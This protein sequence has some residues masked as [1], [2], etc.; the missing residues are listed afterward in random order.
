[1]IKT[2]VIHL[3]D[4][5]TGST[6]LQSVLRSGGYT[7]PSGQTVFYPGESLNQNRM[8]N[9][10][11]QSSQSR[12]FS[13]VAEEFRASECDFGVISAELFQAVDPKDLKQ[14]LEQEMPDFID[15]LR[16]ISYVRPHAEKLVSTFSE[17]AKFGKVADDLRDHFK[18]TRSKKKF[19]YAPRFE[20]WRST[21]G[22]KFSLRLFQR[23][24]L[25][26][27]DV[28]EDFFQWMLGETGTKV[29]AQQLSNSALTA[30]QIAL[31]R[32]FHD[33]LQRE[34]FSKD[35]GRMPAAVAR[36][37]VAQ[38]RIS[39]LGETSERVTLPPKLVTSIQSTYKK[40]AA[41][42]DEMF[43]EGTPMSHALE[44]VPEKLIG[45]NKDFEAS[46]FFSEET[47]QAFDTMAQMSI[48]LMGENK[49]QLRKR[50]NQVRAK[51][52]LKR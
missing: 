40:D 17:Q 27:G 28:V 3:G 51:T 37:L 33:L 35:K 49:K 45:V 39:G 1:M 29:N 11:A 32:R 46:R 20:K 15:R 19:H 25:L 5:K 30:G 2:L 18:N 23:N 14:A 50:A 42:L 41:K 52:K 13:S 9:S 22:D 34:G 38:F 21:F 7:T 8:P 16:L 31:L 26:N 48:L 36:A 12:I 10:V 24:A 43:F 6:A 4:T 47:L 44:A